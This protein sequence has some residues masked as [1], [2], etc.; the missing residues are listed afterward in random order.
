MMQP[1]R[2]SRLRLIQAILEFQRVLEFHRDREGEGAG[3]FV[4]TDVTDELRLL[5]N[6]QR[7]GLEFGEQRKRDVGVG[8]RGDG[9]ETDGAAVEDEGLNY[10]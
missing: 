4:L 9:G 2:N 7:V 5:G 1:M 3:R 6:E 10:S 8:G